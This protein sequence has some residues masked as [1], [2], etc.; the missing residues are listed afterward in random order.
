MLG[1]GEGGATR[2][3]GGCS[4]KMEVCVWWGGGGVKFYPYKNVFFLILLFIKPF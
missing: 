2:G 4:G 3:G 1:T